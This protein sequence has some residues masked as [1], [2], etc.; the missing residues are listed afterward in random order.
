MDGL[1]GLT[2]STS[3][4]GWMDWR[5][6]GV[7]EISTKAIAA[8]TSSTIWPKDA[9][10]TSRQRWDLQFEKEAESI[11]IIAKLGSGEVL[12]LYLWCIVTPWQ[13]VNSTS[14]MYVCW[15]ECY[16]FPP[17]DVIVWTNNWVKRWPGWRGGRGMEFQ[18][19]IHPAGQSLYHS[20][21]PLHNPI[22]TQ[23]I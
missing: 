10:K 18:A 7:P 16:T 17:T 20:Q 11:E 19:Y 22:S 21:N 9:S 2:A 15:F 1:T 13:T 23:H 5:V 4:S 8:K 14:V 6:T 12:W 3:T